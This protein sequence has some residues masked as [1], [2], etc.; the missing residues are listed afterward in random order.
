MKRRKGKKSWKFSTLLSLFLAVAMLAGSLPLTGFEVKAA[1]DDNTAKQSET[2]EKAA[3]SG[4]NH[5]GLLHSQEDLTRVWQNV[6]NN[7]SPN[8]ETWDALWW[9]T[10]SNPSWWPRPL[11]GVTRGGGRDSINQLRIDIRRAYQNALIWKLSGDEAHGEA[12][13]RIINAWS[14]TMKWLGGNA[15]RFLA[16]GLQG[17]E[18]ANIG[19]DAGS[20]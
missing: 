11:E 13:C 5:P 17:Y 7:V 6:E 10:F 8:K 1:A 12:A 19:A 16:A 3:N 2:T 14:S 20:S 15:D 9:D 4:F 18:L